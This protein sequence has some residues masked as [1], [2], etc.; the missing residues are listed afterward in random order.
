MPMILSP[1]SVR[2]STPPSAITLV[3]D[4]GG[5][6]ALRAAHEDGRRTGYE[7]ATQALNLQILEQRTQIA[8]LQENTLKAISCQF[9]SLVEDVRRALPSLAIDVARRA[10]AG[11]VL[12]VGQV[13]AIADEALAELAPGTPGVKLRLSPQD[14]RMVEAL[15]GEFGQRYPGLELVG[16]P[17]LHS[18]DCLASSQFGTIDARLAGKLENIAQALL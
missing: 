13:K 11:V 2:F 16:D 18:G 1:K 3:R 8:N 14:L 9:G 17:D 6:E 10:L 15:A 5:N 4:A 12:D 7:E